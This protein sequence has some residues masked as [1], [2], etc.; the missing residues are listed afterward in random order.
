MN[1]SIAPTA[2]LPALATTSSGRLPAARSAPI[3]PSSASGRMRPTWSLRITRTWSGPNPSTRAARASD[4]CAWSDMY[5][6]ARA[7]ISPISASRAQASAV[8]FAADPPETSAPP[9][10]AG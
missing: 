1:G 4:E 5:S 9:A 8:R 6:T 10:S 7:S 3:A 2:V